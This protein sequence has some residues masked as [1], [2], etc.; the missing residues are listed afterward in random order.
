MKRIFFTTFILLTV[1][2]PS[3]AQTKG[4]GQ[5]QVVSKDDVTTSSD[6]KLV[7]S[8]EFDT[9]GKVSE[10]R[11][12]F[13]QGF[14]RNHELQWYQ[15]D[16]AFVKNGF[17]TIEAREANRPNPHYRA[18]AKDWRKARPAITC[19][20]SSINTQGKFSFLYGRMEVRARIPDGY[21]AWPAIWLLGNNLPW[22]SNGEID[23]MEYYRSNG[24]PSILANA[25]WGDT[26]PYKAI[27]NSKVTPLTHFTK[28][29]PFWTSRFH[30]W[31]MDWDETYIRIYLD[32]EL[33]NE[34]DLSTTVNKSVDGINPFHAPQYILLNLA[35]GGDNGGDVSSD[36]FPMRYDIDYVRVYQKKD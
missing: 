19:T 8:E 33:L 1:A 22:P 26:Q 6:Y 4:K 20:S 17:L 14:V 9:D 25:A 35:I 32:D 5:P 7:W 12:N 15:E 11:W 24:V 34:I 30:I 18:N 31:R 36:C 23:V 21:G 13:E 27:W 3:L 2:L 28:K 16:N 29:D 10:A